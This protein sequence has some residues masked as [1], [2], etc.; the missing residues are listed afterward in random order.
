MSTPYGSL[1][2]KE[3]QSDREHVD[4]YLGSVQDAF[5]AFTLDRETNP[6]SSKA[7]T[8]HNAAYR[9]GVSLKVSVRRA[10]GSPR[11]VIERAA[12]IRRPSGSEIIVPAYGKPLA[13][14]CAATAVFVCSA[15]GFPAAPS[16]L[17]ASS[18]ILALSGSAGSAA[19]LAPGAT[20]TVAGGGYADE[21]SVT[22]AVYSSPVELAHVMADAS[23]RVDTSVTLPTGLTGAHTLTAIG[24]APDGSAHS[25]EAAVILSAASTATVLP[26]T[27]IDVA[28]YLLGGFGMILAGFVLVRTTVFRRRLLPN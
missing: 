21:A 15:A 18:G 9:R 13:G 20:V 1:S 6:S 7:S 24:D 3:K 19:T 14:F 17:P 22:I 16:S 26:F 10:E 12:L 28:G 4:G 5:V 11:R 8:C 23:G 27:G 2:E 25:L